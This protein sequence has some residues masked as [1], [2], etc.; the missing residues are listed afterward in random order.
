MSAAPVMIMAGGTGGHVFPALAVA[1]R[2]RARGVPVVWLG[3]QRGLETK[4]VPPAGIPLEQIAVAGLRGTGLRRRLMAPLMLGRALLQA[5]G[6]LRR[7]RPCLVLGMGGFVSGP[8]G[9]MARLLGIPLVIHEQ[10]ARPG[11]TNRWL[12]RLANQVLTAFPD[13]FP[14]DRALVV[15]NPVRA[16]IT[17]VAEPAERFAGRTGPARLLVVGGSQGARALNQRVP[18]ALALLPAE[19]R[20]EVRHQAGGQ[21]YEMTVAAYQAAGVSA[22]LEP[23]IED[24]A[25]A[26][27]WADLVLCRA[28]ALTVAELAAVGVGAI[29][30]PFPFAIDDHQ[31][32]NAGFLE[33]AGAALILHQADLDAVRLAEQ[34]RTLLSDRPRLLV[35]AQAARRLA[36]A[37]AAEQVATLCLEQVRT[38]TPS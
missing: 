7:H 3:S 24:M 25:A 14:A 6:V 28:G 26:Y 33:R 10:N 34:L 4:L 8:G 29:L 18:A 32:A 38:G 13:S 16:S 35:M 23:F 5:M 36:R 11:T 37:D 17:A 1:E 15:G 12:A 19:Q 22:R 27:G 31:T 2:L 30:V 21:L 20:P 9:L